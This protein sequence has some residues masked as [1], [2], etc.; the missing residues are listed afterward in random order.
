[1]KKGKIA[2]NG[3]TPAPHERETLMILAG[4]G[5]DIEL[6]KPSLT[7]YAKTGDFV[8]LGAVWEMKSPTGK[9]R[10]TMEHV[11]QKAAHQAR[12]VVIDLRRSKIPDSQAI[13]DLKRVFA[14]SRSVRNL[15]IVDKEQNIRKLRK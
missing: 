4:R 2:F 12:N 15:W 7:K 13:S 6:L 14:T 9:S 3:I 10:Y 5:Y 1:M 8:M 11:F